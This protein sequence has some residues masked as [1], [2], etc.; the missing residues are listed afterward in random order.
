MRSS[1]RSPWLAP[2]RPSTSRAIKR[3]AVKPIISR[4]R[5]ASELFSKR[6]RRAIMSSV[7]VVSSLG[8]VFLAITQPYTGNRDGRPLWITGLARPDSRRSLRQ[9][10]YPQLLHH[11]AGHDQVAAV[12]RRGDGFRP[13]ARSPSRT[14]SIPPGPVA[15][16][17]RHG[18]WH[19][20]ASSRRFFHNPRRISGSR[21]AQEIPMHN[22]EYEPGVPGLVFCPPAEHRELMSGLA[23]PFSMWQC[24]GH[25]DAAGPGFVR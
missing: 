22:R 1:E 17:D 12:V 4:S 9:A 5:S 3:W 10:S 21:P 2:V 14:G 18:P 7:I 15:P 16:P 11:A 25:G 6:P 19:R 13:I 23:I 8:Q 24:A 20:E